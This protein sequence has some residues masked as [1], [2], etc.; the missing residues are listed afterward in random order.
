M[1]YAS[2]A[3][4]ETYLWVLS[5]DPASTGVVPV[6]DATAYSD[7]AGICPVGENLSPA[8]FCTKA[9][10]MTFYVD[11][12]GSAGGP[13]TPE[14]PVLLVDMD[15]GFRRAWGGRHPAGGRE[16]RGFSQCLSTAC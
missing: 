2:Q 7:Y 11:N 16:R 12:D 5:G 9:Q 8:M 1:D 13:G 4:M 6:Y 14:K 3:G 10:V 15:S